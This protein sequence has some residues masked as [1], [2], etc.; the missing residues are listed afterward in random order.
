MTYRAV[1]FDY[2]GVLKGTLWSEFERKM[3]AVLDV[4]LETYKEAF[5]AQR[6]HG[7]PNLGKTTWAE[8]WERLVVGIGRADRLDAVATLNRRHVAESAINEDVV[9]IAR[10]I[11]AIGCRIGI[12]TNNVIAARDMIRVEGLEAL[13]DAVDISEETGFAKP[14]PAAF[15][16]LAAALG[17]EVSELIFIDDNTSSL[18]KATEIGYTPILFT[19]APQ[20]RDEL[21]SFDLLQSSN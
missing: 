16:H 6:A 14:E 7:N 3:A 21:V 8:F 2:D 18:R 20:L 19:S 15:K 11:K 9:A 13:F 10:E 4:P 1:G 12:L 5:S 17:V